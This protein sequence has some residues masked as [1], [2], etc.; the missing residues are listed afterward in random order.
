MDSVSYFRFLLFL[1]LLCWPVFAQVP[2]ASTTFVIN[3]DRVKGSDMCDDG[4]K[5][6]I[7]LVDG[8][9]DVI[10]D[11]LP[12]S[13]V[14]LKVRV[15]GET[16][17]N[18]IP[19][20]DGNG[21]WAV[22]YTLYSGGDHKMRITLDGDEIQG[23]PIRW[24]ADY[25]TSVFCD[26]TPPIVLLVF[27]CV[28]AFL[29]LLFAVLSIV[30]RNYW[31][32]KVSHLAFL[33]IL[34]FGCLLSLIGGGLILLFPDEAVC[35][36][37]LWFW[38]LGLALI[39]AALLAKTFRLW[40]VYS[41]AG[42]LKGSSINMKTLLSV[43]AVLVVVEIVYLSIWMIVDIP[44]RQ[45]YDEDEYDDL[46]RI[47]CDWDDVA[48]GLW[49]GLKVLIIVLALGLAWMSR[50]AR[51]AFRESHFIA[52]T[53]TLILPLILAALIAMVEIGNYED[54][55][56]VLDSSK[57]CKHLLIS[58]QRFLLFSRSVC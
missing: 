31:V 37:H 27:L 4:V 5:V 52:V 9:G 2:S 56:I 55:V 47:R 21:I 7:Q 39:L 48:A 50:V 18:L 43:L 42:A 26:L 13:E 24:D 1:T 11:D 10:T 20:N 51:T 57:P 36:L 54:L 8:S 49:Y 46:S 40:R 35:S 3:R 38:G 15:T 41:T 33:L 12:R 32:F 6:K 23:S 25:D 58:P 16:G 14:P 34:L 29:C 53:L 45:E 30:F 28:L 17:G 44:D 22:R 19:F